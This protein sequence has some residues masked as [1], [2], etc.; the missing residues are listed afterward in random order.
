MQVGFLTFWNN[1]ADG[2][3]DAAFFKQEHAINLMAEP[4][5][6]DNFFCVEHHFNSYSMSP[7]NFQYL[8]YLAG[9]TKRI[10]LA[11]M[12]A[13]LP[14][15][16]PLRVAEKAIL[17]DHISD[18]RALLGMARGLAKREY[19]GF[20]QDLEESRERFDEAALMICDAV[21]TGVME[22]E[23]K[24]Y[25]QPRTTIR[26]GPR[27]SFA[28]RKY[29]VAMSPDTVPVCAQVGA[30]Q[31]I[32]AYKPWPDV[33]PSI[34]EYRRLY[35]THH[36]SEAPPIATVDLTFCSDDVERAHELVGTYFGSFAE[37][38]EIFGEHLANS[39]S[40]SAYSGIGAAREAVGYDAMVDAFVAS[41]VCG[42][43][44]QILEK[45]EE[46]RRIIGDFEP[47][48]IF[49]HSGATFEEV[50]QSI[51]RFAAEVMPE[52]RSWRM[53]EAA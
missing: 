48:L 43:P 38:Y 28:K 35:K 25:P 18:G 53:G 12:G 31:G 49:S 27:G 19:T 26:P 16:D 20:R 51:K 8:S 24:Y 34:Q 32:F 1:Y 40:Y 13:I 39:K 11:T 5:G 46:R 45:Y 10:G 9:Q 44:Q 17:L 50:Q 36:D 6:F 52:L 21:E 2:L 41:N 14:W 30:A 47:I 3:D 4:L 7:D 42:T 23:G 22:G 15:N 33:L 29:M 37:H